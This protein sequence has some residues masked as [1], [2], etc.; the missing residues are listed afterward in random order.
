MK[1][2]FAEFAQKDLSADIDLPDLRS[3]E[4]PIALQWKF[5]LLEHFFKISTKTATD[6]QRM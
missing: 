4:T 2:A 1:K 3:P 5:G 6:W